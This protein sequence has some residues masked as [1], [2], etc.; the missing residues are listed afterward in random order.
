MAGTMT[1]TNQIYKCDICGNVVE[2]EHIGV[3]T[4]VCCGQEMRLE[5]ENRDMSNAQKHIPVIVEDQEGGI[6]ITIGEI[7]HPMTEEH[8]LDWVQIRTANGDIRIRMDLGES[9]VVELPH[10]QKSD[11]LGIRSYCNIHGMYVS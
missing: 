6:K 1:Q 2:V 9:P 7:L 4:L 5:E 3:G 11:I 10:L 8:H